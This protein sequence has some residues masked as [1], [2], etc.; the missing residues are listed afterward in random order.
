MIFSDNGVNEL[1]FGFV[2]FFFLQVRVLDFFAKLHWCCSDGDKA[3]QQ[4]YFGAPM[5]VILGG[6]SIRVRVGYL[7][8]IWGFWGIL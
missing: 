8:L 3:G 4:E 6:K 7:L 1:L 5:V 2:G